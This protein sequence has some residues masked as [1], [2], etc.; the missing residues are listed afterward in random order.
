[1]QSLFRKKSMVLECREEIRILTKKKIII[2]VSAYWM[3]RNKSWN[4]HKIRKYVGPYHGAW[5]ITRC[6]GHQ[7]I[8][9]GFNTPDMMASFPTTE[10]LIQK[11]LNQYQPRFPDHKI[12]IKLKITKD[13]RNPTM[14]SFF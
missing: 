13:D 4:E 9:G 6:K 14:E 10:S 12:I 1:M 2:E 5:T 7:D 3:R 8:N 11:F